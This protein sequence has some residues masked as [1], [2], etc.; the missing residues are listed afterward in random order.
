MDSFELKIWDAAYP[1]ASELAGG[2]G[3][4]TYPGSISFFSRRLGGRPFPEV[5]TATPIVPAAGAITR[6]KRSPKRKATSNIRKATNAKIDVRYLPTKYTQ[7]PFLIA[8]VSTNTSSLPSP[9][10]DIPACM[11]R[12]HAHAYLVQPSRVRVACRPFSY[13]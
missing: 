5:R 8:P 11:Y 10:L 4:W 6:E 12:A 13:M 7:N 2:C 3:G 9:V 1:P